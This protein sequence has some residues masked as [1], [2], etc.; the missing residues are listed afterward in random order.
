VDG[1]EE[2][3]DGWTDGLWG[4]LGEAYAALQQVG[5]SSGPVLG[6]RGGGGGL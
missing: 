5:R 2:V 4:P 6:R 3:V 1:L